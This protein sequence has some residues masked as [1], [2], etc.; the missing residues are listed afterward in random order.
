MKKFFVVLSLVLSSCFISVVFS[1][2]A[3]AE[4][5]TY[6]DEQIMRIL[7]KFID[8]G[9]AAN[10]ERNTWTFSKA[11]QCYLSQTGN[12]YTVSSMMKN[13]LSEFYAITIV[14]L[15][16]NAMRW[17]EAYILTNPMYGSLVKATGF[18]KSWQTG[19]VITD[20]CDYLRAN[21][22]EINGVEK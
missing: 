3:F 11:N 9:G 5:Q 1:S 12:L 18:N 15:N 14:D 13:D 17:V 16:G 10:S 20:Y 8:G 4:K 2:V 22:K 6:T 7:Y 19:E 21:Y